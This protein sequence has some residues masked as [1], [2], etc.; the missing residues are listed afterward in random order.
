MSGVQP[1]DPVVLHKYRILA[2]EIEQMLCGGSWYNVEAGNAPC[3]VRK[4]EHDAM[5]AALP[6]CEQEDIQAAALIL[7]LPRASRCW[8][9]DRA[10]GA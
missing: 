10:S 8:T 4:A 7:G 6:L 9:K 5:M 2:G 1:G 3:E